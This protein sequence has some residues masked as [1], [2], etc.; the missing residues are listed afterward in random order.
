MNEASADSTRNTTGSNASHR[1]AVSARSVPSRNRRPG[2]PAPRSVGAASPSSGMAL[3]MSWR[4]PPA[5]DDHPRVGETSQVD[6]PAQLVGRA[7]HH[8][9]A[10]AA[11]PGGG[12]VHHGPP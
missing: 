6:E 7:R 10:V 3:M 1:E 11:E 12:P 8:D 9:G 2:R 4:L 5:V